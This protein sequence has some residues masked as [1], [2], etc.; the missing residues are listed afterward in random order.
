[1]MRRCSSSNVDVPNGITFTT[2]RLFSRR[3]SHPFIVNSETGSVIVFWR[4]RPLSR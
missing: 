2:L 3:L 4:S 1:M